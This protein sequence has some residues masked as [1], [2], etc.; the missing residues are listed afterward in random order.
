MLAF[1]VIVIVIVIINIQ[2]TTTEE[3]VIVP[4]RVALI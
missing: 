1:G 2:T 3:F 4:C